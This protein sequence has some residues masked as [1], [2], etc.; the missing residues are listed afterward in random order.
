MARLSAP[1]ADKRY[2]QGQIWLMAT[3]PGVPVALR[4][5]VNSYGLAADEFTTTGNWPDRAFYLREGRHMVREYQF[6]Q[7]DTQTALTKPDPI[8]MGGWFVDCHYCGVCEYDGK[9]LF[10]G[11]I[12]ETVSKGAA[13]IKIFQIP[14]RSIVPK[15]A[16]VTNLWVNYS[17]SATHIG[18]EPIRIEWIYMTLGEAAATAAVIANLDKSTAQA[19]PYPELASKLQPHGGVFSL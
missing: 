7:Q 4:D 12:D 17:Q 5:Q 1:L 14:Y 10:E 9:L 19:V 3:D 18:Y 2:Q 6:R 11:Y 16:E 15:A 8:G 13:D